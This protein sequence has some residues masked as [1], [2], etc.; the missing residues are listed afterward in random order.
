MRK[1]FK[2]LLLIT[3]AFWL[4][5]ACSTGY[6]VVETS[7]AN[8]VITNLEV[9][10]DSSIVAIYAPFKAELEAEMN[11]V[12][13]FSEIDLVKGKPESP[14]TNFLADLV[15][16]EALDRANHTNPPAGAHISFLNYGGIRTGLPK[17]EILVGHLFELMPFENELVLLQLPA[18]EV[19]A[20]LDLI[21]S[22]GGDSLSGVRFRIANGK[23]TEIVIDG[24]PFDPSSNYWLATSDYVA[25]GGDSYSMLRNHAARVETGEKIRDVMILYLSKT[26]AN[27]EIIHPKTDGRIVYE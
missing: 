6:V 19:Q 14:L 11:K 9:P 10:V 25:D 17:G 22:R 15:L 7:H 1:A 3:L 8:Q 5:T 21:A 13:G 26:Y 24:V 27:G 18:R 20:F 12:V 2:S 16:S 23:A 4:L